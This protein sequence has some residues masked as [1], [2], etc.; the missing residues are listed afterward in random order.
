M[1]MRNERIQTDTKKP[2]TAKRTYAK[3][4]VVANSE[5]TTLYVGNLRYTS[6]EK[7]LRAVFSQFGQ[8]GEIKFVTDPQTDKNIGIAFIKMANKTQALQAITAMNG[9]QLNGRTLKVSEAIPLKKKFYE[10]EYESDDDVISNKATRQAKPKTK[11]TTTAKP[12]GLKVLFNY[13][14]SKK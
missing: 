2:L 13:L 7:G 3:K 4:E 11:K 6:T 9:Y 5:E 14:G 10:T 12:K 8:V 1:N